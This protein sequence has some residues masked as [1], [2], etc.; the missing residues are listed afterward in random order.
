M[1]PKG[2]PVEVQNQ[3]NHLIRLCHANHVLLTGFAF[4]MN[5]EDGDFLLHFG[6]IDDS[7][8]NI[9]RLH[10]TLI[11]VLSEQNPGRTI[12]RKTDA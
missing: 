5:G 12:L 2:I 10:D 9:Q 7:Y 1:E 8:D 3:V 4:R 6:T 11:N